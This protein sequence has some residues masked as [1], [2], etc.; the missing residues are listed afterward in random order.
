MV[1]K[2]FMPKTLE[3]GGKTFLPSPRTHIPEILN[4]FKELYKIWI[5]KNDFGVGET[6]AEETAWAI[7]NRI[8]GTF[9]DEENPAIRCESLGLLANDYERLT[10]LF[11]YQD[12]SLQ[13]ADFRTLDL[14][15]NAFK[16][17]QILETYRLNAIGVIISAY[18]S[19]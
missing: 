18:G 10:E 14:S 8:I 4:D 6:I 15:K 7:M 9:L 3:I 11:F 2:I 13:S 19:D 12:L 5:V 17:S 16:G 1:S